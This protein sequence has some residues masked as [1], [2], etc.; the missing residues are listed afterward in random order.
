VILSLFLK[1]EL[2]NSVIRCTVSS[3]VCISC[4]GEKAL[5]FPVFGVYV[6]S[7]LFV[8]LFDGDGI[9]CVLEYGI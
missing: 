4:V 3:I 7:V 1:I 5:S 9:H 2:L 8:H 6:L